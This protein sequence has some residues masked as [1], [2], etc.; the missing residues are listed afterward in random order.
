MSF[1]KNCLL[2]AGDKIDKIIGAATW[3]SILCI[4][5]VIAVGVHLLF[6]ECN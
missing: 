5:G 6:C 2:F 4:A 3:F 1:K